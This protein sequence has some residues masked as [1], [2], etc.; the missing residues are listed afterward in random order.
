MKDI[1]Q[2]NLEIQLEHLSVE[3]IE[4]LYEKTFGNP[5]EH[6]PSM[7]VS[8]MKDEIVQEHLSRYLKEA[9]TQD[10]RNELE[11]RGYQ[12]NNLWHNEDVMLK[13]DCE[14]EEAQEVLIAALNN[15]ATIEQVH[16]AIDI[17]AEMLDL[18][19]KSDE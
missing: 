3:E 6:Y 16:L 15:E 1:R 12:T 17:V 9:S 10:L 4:S 13:Y 14:S 19:P 2:I 8:Q 18:K 7:E 5:I 11:L